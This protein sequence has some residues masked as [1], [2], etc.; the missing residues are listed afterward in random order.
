MRSI[1][2]MVNASVAAVPGTDH[3][4]ALVIAVDQAHQIAQH[5]AMLVAQAQS[6]AGSARHR[7]GSFKKIAMPVGTSCQALGAS[8]SGAS[9][10]A[11]KSSPALP[12]VA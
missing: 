6:A 10:Q 11:R 3:Q 4:L 7:L 9:R 8:V 5:D 1:G 12:G 2:A